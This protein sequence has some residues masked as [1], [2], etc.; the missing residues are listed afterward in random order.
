MA[1]MITTAIATTMAPLGKLVRFSGG[2]TGGSMPKLDADGRSG[3]GF[4]EDCQ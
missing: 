2:R 3:G 1:K 4:C